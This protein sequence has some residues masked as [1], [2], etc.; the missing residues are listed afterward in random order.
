MRDMQLRVIRA[1]QSLAQL[2]R[3]DGLDHHKLAHLSLVQELD[4]AGDLGK[5]RIVFAAA[6][7]QA[8]FYRSSTLP[9]NNCSAGNNLAAKC[10]KAE[11]LCV[12]IATVS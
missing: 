2:L 3:F 4:A 9:H 5:E 7:V 11:P 6:H 10:L 8:R 1:S 12:G